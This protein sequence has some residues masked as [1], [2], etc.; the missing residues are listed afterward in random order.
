MIQELHIKNFQSHKDSKLEFSPGVNVI[1]GDSDSGKSAIIR[2]LQWVTFNKPSGDAFRSTWGGDTMVT[3]RTADGSVTRRK[4]DHENSYKLELEMPSVFT[5]FGQ[6]IPEPIKKFLNLDEVN[7]QKQLD[8]PFLLSDT[9]GQIA[10]Y[11]N[12]IAGIDIIDKSIKNCQKEIRETSSSIKYVR[13]D[14]K[15]KKN[16]LLQFDYLESIESD[17]VELEQLEKVK[18]NLVKEKVEIAQALLKFEKV[19]KEQDEIYFLLQLEDYVLDLL[20]LIN[21]RKIALSKKE[22]L[23]QLLFKIEKTTKRIEQNKT[24][25][26]Y[27]EPVNNLLKLLDEK[28]VILGDFKALKQLIGKL[29][30]VSDLMA[31]NGTEI[32]K[33]QGVFD[34]HLTVCPLCGTKVK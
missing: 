32:A 31:K 1:I 3:V 23:N 26:N 24:L 5:G 6:D 28:S 11:F 25:L 30:T 17:L 21:N 12:R 20:E 10:A 7:L 29:T 9:P 18:R 34:Q 19:T 27:S 13:E 22:A 2:A 33:K 16:Q 15:Q 14:L 4:G 8:A